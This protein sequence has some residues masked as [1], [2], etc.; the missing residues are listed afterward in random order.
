M[1]ATP[2]EPPSYTSTFPSCQIV[3]TPALTAPGASALAVVL[4]EQVE[5]M[6]VAVVDVHAVVKA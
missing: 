4:T 5:P 1:L 6:V 3:R 2:S